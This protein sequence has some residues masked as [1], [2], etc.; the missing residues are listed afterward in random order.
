[1]LADFYIT[2]L[3]NDMN[4]GVQKNDLGGQI[5]DISTIKKTTSDWKS[6]KFALE[7]LN[8]TIHNK[9]RFNCQKSTFGEII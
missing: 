7:N 6:V 3:S 5:L 1:M 2:R 4:I 9:C 8:F